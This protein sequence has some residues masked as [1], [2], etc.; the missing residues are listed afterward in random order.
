MLVSRLSF[1]IV[2]TGILILP[3]LTGC[4][5]GSG[6]DPDQKAIRDNTYKLFTRVKVNDKAVIYE[7]EFPYVK[8]ERDVH[9]Y[10]QGRFVKAYNADTLVA[11]QVDSVQV[12]GDSALSYLRLEYVQ[13]DSSFHIQDLKLLW[14]KYEGIWIKPSLSNIDRQLEFEEELRIYW[15]AVREMDRQ[16]GN[17]TSGEGES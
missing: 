12:T 8:E 4:R 1:V 13:A 7:N 10:L 15:D 5:E 14:R 2:L 3:I 6:L 9:E 17:E 11:L 16:S